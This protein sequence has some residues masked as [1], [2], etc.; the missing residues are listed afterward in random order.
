[1]HN[2]YNAFN[3][4][5]GVI[6][7]CCVVLF[8]ACSKT[9]IEPVKIIEL[10][11]EI[12]TKAMQAY[13]S[14]LSDRYVSIGYIYDWG[15]T[16][17]S[18]L[19]HTPDSLDIIVVKNGYDHLSIAQITDLNDVKSKKATKVLL[20][21][22]FNA[23]VITPSDLADTITV[24]QGRR[25][26]EL[27]AEGA[28]PAQ[29]TTELAKVKTDTENWAKAIAVYQ[30][31]NLMIKA[32]ELIREY[33]FDGIS[34]LLP[35]NSGYLQEPVNIFF[36]NLG[37]DYGLGKQNIL[38]IENPDIIYSDV[39]VKANW[40]VYNKQTPDYY[41]TY[42]TEDAAKLP[43][44]KFVPSAD[45]TN[46]TDTDGFL[47][48]ETFSATG[49][50]PRTRDIVNWKASNKGGAAFYHIEKNYTD[51]S[52]NLTY[53]SLRHAIRELQFSE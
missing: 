35:V 46:E 42:F 27:T 50:L 25:Q 40:L 34:I 52:G 28:G 3:I 13:K 19:M 14:N 20:G 23:N 11:R 33:K 49:I 6:V 2:K 5:Q 39:L 32:N 8:A 1:M 41:L 12:D 51:I 44:S 22:D 15:N 21:L 29:I 48:S 9:S 30:Y 31:N 17:A 53:N 7:C 47:D 24:R 10:K 43:G 37:A 38:V 16:D 4:T 45:Y 18:I 26:Q 36:Q